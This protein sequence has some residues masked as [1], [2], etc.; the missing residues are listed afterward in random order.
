MALGPFA[1]GE[2]PSEPLVIA[3]TNAVGE[4]LDLDL[5]DSLH[6]DGDA[7]PAGTVTIASAP[8]GK[9]QY[10]FSEAFTVAGPVEARVRLVQD[11]G[12]V[13]YSPWFSFDVLPAYALRVT[14]VEAYVFTAQSVTQAQ[15][16]T[17]QAQVAMVVD[18][19]LADDVIWDGLWSRD[20][21]LLQQAIAW[22]AAEVAQAAVI[23]VPQM[24]GVQSMSTANQSITFTAGSGTAPSVPVG[25]MSLAILKRLSWRLRQ[26]SSYVEPERVRPDA[27][28]VV[29]RLDHL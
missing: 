8:E 20:R 1:V 15:L 14:P 5:Y 28:V 3:V 9:L 26:L 19:L 23:G 16:L 7:L 2:Q 22:Q 6:F 4:P 29:N 18:R 21:S 27:W 11:D 17:A 12:D 25:Q 24:A 13:D 10:T